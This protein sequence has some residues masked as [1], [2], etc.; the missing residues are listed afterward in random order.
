MCDCI[1]QAY[2]GMGR[3]G[4]KFCQNHLARCA[5]GNFAQLLRLWQQWICSHSPTFA[6]IVMG[7]QI[8]ASRLGC[9]Q[10]DLGPEFR[11][12]IVKG[13]WPRGPMDKASAYGA[14]DCRFESCRGHFF[15]KSP[16]GECCTLKAPERRNRT[17]ACLHAP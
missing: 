3:N 15:S 8:P 6:N 13:H 9:S 16:Q 2:C 10:A 7:R 4:A 1:K 17:P 14:G 11:R 5:L 12:V